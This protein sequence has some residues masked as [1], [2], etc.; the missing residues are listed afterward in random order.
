[1]ENGRPRNFFLGYWDGPAIGREEGERQ[2]RLRDE[3]GGRR[4]ADATKRLMGKMS[5]SDLRRLNIL[6]APRMAEPGTE[7]VIRGQ[8]AERRL[9]A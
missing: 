1:M 2:R 8:A 9:A 5:Y 3:D 4:L 6:T 7:N